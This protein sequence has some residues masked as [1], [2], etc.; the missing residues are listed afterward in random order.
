MHPD[1][2]PRF[3]EKLKP[4][5]SLLH[6]L[7][8]SPAT[9]PLALPPSVSGPGVYLFSEQGADLYVGRTRN[10]RRRIR[11]HANVGSSHRVAAFAFRL[12]REAT[13]HLSATY[14][15]EGSRDDLSNNLEFAAALVK[16]KVRIHS[17]TVRTIAIEDDLTQCLFEIYAAT[18]LSTRHNT[19]RTH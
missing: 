19:F 8:S 16:Q 14:S 3:L 17:M 1:C 15:T 6:Q 11:Q 10:L 12:A 5:P 9:S 13:G 18:V 7:V 4:L 2:D